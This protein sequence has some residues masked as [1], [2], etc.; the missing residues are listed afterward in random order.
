MAASSVSGAVEASSFASV[1]SS[2]FASVA[3]SSFASDASG[4]SLPRGEETPH[5][6]EAI[7]AS[8][9]GEVQFTRVGRGHSG[10]LR[11]AKGYLIG[12]QTVNGPAFCEKWFLS[13][14]VEA[15]PGD[16]EFV[17]FDEGTGRH[18]AVRSSEMTEATLFQAVKGKMRGTRTENGGPHVSL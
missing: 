5:V 10:F 1:A 4:R 8:P 17:F 2:S 15:L 11:N 7:Y 6:I 14:K 16:C 18:L 3:S 9:V 12:F 13:D